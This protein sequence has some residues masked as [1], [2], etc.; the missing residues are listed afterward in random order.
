M[1]NYEETR[2]KLTNTRLN[3]LKFASKNTTGTTLRITQ[4]NFQDK[5]LPHELILTTKQK[6]EM[7]SIKTCQKNIVK[8][9]CLK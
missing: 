5:E 6:P 8:L 7:F 4:K 1:A 9:S 3:K 2:V